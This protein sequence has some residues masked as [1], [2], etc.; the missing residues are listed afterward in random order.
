VD[1]SRAI[2]GLLALLAVLAL[3]VAAATLDSAGGTG[4]S[5]LGDS[6]EAGGGGGIDVSQPPDDYGPISDLIRYVVAVLLVV[7]LLVSVVTFYREYG[8]RGLASVAI[9]GAV[10]GVVIYVVLQGFEPPGSQ[11]QNS[12]GVPSFL[13]TGG[14]PG[15]GDD[16]GVRRRSVPVLVGVLFLGLLG[17]GLLLVRATGDDAQAPGPTVAESSDVEQLGRVAGEAA[18]RIARGAVT[19]NEVYRAWREMTDHLDVANP[20]ASTPGEFADAAVEAGLAREDVEELT[21][22]FAEVRYG[23]REATDEREERAVAA[24]RRIEEGYA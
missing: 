21:S 15:T 3:G 12:S 5:G 8:V 14:E 6:D 17:A 18:E 2:V 23:D 19:N 20:D 22:L 10:L 16:S 1:R 4:G 11:S 13:P 24:L 7:G 9:A